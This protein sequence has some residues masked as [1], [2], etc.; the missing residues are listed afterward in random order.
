LVNRGVQSFYRR[1][2]SRHFAGECRSV[3]KL[4]SDPT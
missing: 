1:L 3:E 4:K 2:V